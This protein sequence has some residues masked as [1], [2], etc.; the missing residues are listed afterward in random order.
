MIT[1]N[2][3]SHENSRYICRITAPTESKAKELAIKALIPARAISVTG[4]VTNSGQTIIVDT[5]S[6]NATLKISNCILSLLN[7]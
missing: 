2:D 1:K 7:N 5:D 4:E 3:I 6:S